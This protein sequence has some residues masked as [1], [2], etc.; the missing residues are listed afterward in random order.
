MGLHLAGDGGGCLSRHM[1]ATE[2]QLCWWP[3]TAEE[4]S[5]PWHPCI[6]EVSV[7]QAAMCDRNRPGPKQAFQRTEQQTSGGEWWRASVPSFIPS[8]MF[9]DSWVAQWLNVGLRL[10]A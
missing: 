7:L 4:L 3:R 2:T 1:A 5:P 9:I 8:K 6:Y 10:R